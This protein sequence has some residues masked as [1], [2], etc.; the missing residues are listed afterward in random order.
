MTCKN[1]VH[2]DVCSKEDGTT[3]YYGEVIIC[4]DV[5]ELCKYFKD[6]SR[7]V[8]LPCKVGDNFFIIDQSLEKG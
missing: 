5:D 6:K 2:Y 1:C 3:N 7:I 8:E 4:K